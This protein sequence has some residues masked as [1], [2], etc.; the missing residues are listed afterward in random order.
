MQH[1]VYRN[2]FLRHKNFLFSNFDRQYVVSV[3][4]GL[5]RTDRTTASFQTPRRSPTEVGQ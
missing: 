4:E 2:G 1:A 3:T 5:Q